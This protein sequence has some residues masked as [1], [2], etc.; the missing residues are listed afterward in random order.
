MREKEKSDRWKSDAGWL[1][2]RRRRKMLEDRHREARRE[3]APSSR[4]PKPRP[5]SPTTYL[6]TD[7]HDDGCS[8]PGCDRT[9]FGTY[10]YKSAVHH[11]RFPVYRRRHGVGSELGKGPASVCRT[12][13]SRRPKPAPRVS[14]ARPRP[15]ATRRARPPQ[16][17][18][19]MRPRASFG[20]GPPAQPPVAAHHRMSRCQERA[21]CS[22]LP[23][24]PGSTSGQRAAAS[25]VRAGHIRVGPSKSFLPAA[26]NP[27]AVDPPRR[28]WRPA[29]RTSFQQ[30][31]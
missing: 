11:A 8:V 26:G 1:P 20:S 9:T 5:R 31:C 25:H 6:P 29:P 21:A 4:G 2:T 23:A 24:Q 18:A 7:I 17:A 14:R 3:G 22:A 16:S 28:R 10:T 12:A 30:L 13:G 27:S 15:A 19:L